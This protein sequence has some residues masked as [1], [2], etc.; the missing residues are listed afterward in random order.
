MP[1]FFSAIK[2]V[3]AKIAERAAA[4]TAFKIIQG[5]GLA[6]SVVSGVKSFRIARDMQNKGQGI[7]A[8][9]T[10]AGGKIPVIYGQR[11]VGAQI[12]YMD[13]ADN[14]SK[15]LFVVYALAVGEVEEIVGNTIE[16]DGNSITDTK[17][18]RDGWYLGSD[19]ISSGAGSLNTASQIGTNNG[20]ASAGSSGTDPSKRYRAVFNLHHGAASQTADPMLTASIS[21]KWTSAHKLNG[22]AY[23]ACS[24][25]YDTKGIF[26]GVPQLT[27]VVKGRKVFDPRTAAGQTF[28]NTSTYT[29]SDNAALCVLDYITNDEYGKGLG[30]TEV[31]FDT[32]GTAADACDTAVSYTHLRAHET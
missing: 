22:I 9:K 13:T 2:A 8:N 7:L 3:F 26:R 5:V 25:E 6:V 24:F 27:V 14:R 31:N 19:K 28:G 17:R 4:S 21:S 16:L 32:F 20:S 12:V 10:A 18:F 23:I 29:W 11:R 30:S 15:D 1:E